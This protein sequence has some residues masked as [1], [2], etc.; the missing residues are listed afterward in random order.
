MPFSV[1]PLPSVKVGMLVQLQFWHL[2]PVSE[3]IELPKSQ[4][5]SFVSD[6]LNFLD[7]IIQVNDEVF[8]EMSSRKTAR[9]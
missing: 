2:L 1:D 7:F 5:L 6:S 3:L 9:S 8:F 4:L